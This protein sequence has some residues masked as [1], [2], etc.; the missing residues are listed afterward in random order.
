MGDSKQGSGDRWWDVFAKL[1]PLLIGLFVTGLGTYATNVYRAKEFQL[2][3]LQALNEFR[4]LLQSDVPVDRA[5]AYQAFV[6]L[7]YEDLVV[8]LVRASDDPSGRPALAAVQGP[9]RQAAQ[10]VLAQVPVYVYLHIAEE[11]QRDQ[12]RLIQA[13]I[14]DELGFVVPGIENIAGKAGVPSRA[15]VRYFAESDAK[16]ARLVAEILG[17][18][19][20][21]GA[22]TA[23]LRLR[24]KPG[25]VEVWIP[26]QGTE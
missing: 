20:F 9:T 12:A 24:A 10:D 26:A 6:A 19:G 16:A 18:Y 25:T 2:A 1:T 4:P 21:R 13:A 17:K 7:G 11:G 8:E 3:Q 14:E 23:R 22:T 15:R 5:F